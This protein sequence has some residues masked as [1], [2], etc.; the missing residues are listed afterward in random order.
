MVTNGPD[1]RVLLARHPSPGSRADLDDGYTEIASLKGNVGSQNYEIAA[2]ADLEGSS[3]VVIYCKPFR[4]VFA[5]AT[6][7]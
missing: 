1:L 7:R 2:N 3:S 5:T 6:L 4:V